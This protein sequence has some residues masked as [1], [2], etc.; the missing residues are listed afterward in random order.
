MAVREFVRGRVSWG[1]LEAVAHELLTRTDGEVRIEFI[2]A[3][4]WLSIPCVV[5]DRWF[6]KIVTPR[7]SLVHAIF[8]AGR[9]LGAVSS[10]QPGFFDHFG[11]AAAMVEHEYEATQRMRAAGI[12]APKPV[13]WFVVDDLG[14]LVVEY[15][16]S[17]EP[18]GAADDDR[19][20]AVAPAVFETLAQL[21]DAGFVHGDLRAENV[22][23]CDDGPYLI[24]A[25]NVDTGIEAA[26]AYDL[27]CAL[28]MLAPRIGAD[29][30][31]AVA[32]EVYGTDD[33][34]AAAD[35]LDF[36]AL[37]PDHEFDGPQ[38][39]GEIETLAD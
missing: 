5:D 24:D 39:K 28:A 7:N 38:L 14:V 18:L 9:N 15:L 26:R 11:D 21:H 16:P 31:V 32:A 27:A 35:F 17:F 33:L 4:N 1:R 36:V 12:D 10:G 19:L 22:L 2:D 20:R 30:A 8:T 3:D 23:L 25:T 13:D 29:A 37:R 6:V 34:L